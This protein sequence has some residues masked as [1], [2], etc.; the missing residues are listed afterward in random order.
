[1]IRAFLLGCLLMGSSIASA[2]PMADA[3]EFAAKA[4]AVKK[5]VGNKASFVLTGMTCGSC[6]SKVY[7]ALDKVEG[8]IA[9]AVDYQSGRVEIAFNGKKT[10]KSK[11]QK[12]LEETGYKLKNS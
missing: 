4:E 11:I 2:C 3:A 10:S 5:S 9:T 6:S 8:V 1:M 12:I 7:G